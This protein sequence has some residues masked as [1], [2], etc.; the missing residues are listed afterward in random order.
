[1]VSAVDRSTGASAHT[2]FRVDMRWAQFRKRPSHDGH[3]LGENVLSPATVGGLSLL[4]KH[5]GGIISSP[6]VANGVAYVGS[7]SG[8]VHALNASTGALRW[9]YPTGDLVYSSPA[10]ANGVVYLGLL[11]VYALNIGTGALLWKYQTGGSS[12]AV[13]NGVVYVGWEDGVYAFGLTSSVAPALPERPDPQ[14]L[15][16]D[17]SLPVSRPSAKLPTTDE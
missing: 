5:T 8:K 17:L 9:K 14:T 1:M 16:P 4:W 2:P 3:N 7:N 11:N 6:A 12:P 13:A 15:S 10:V